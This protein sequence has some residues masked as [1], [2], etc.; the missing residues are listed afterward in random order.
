MM[1]LP[2]ARTTRTL[3]EI[4]MSDSDAS[5]K[6]SHWFLTLLI[7]F[8]LGIGASML[9]P[10]YAGPYLDGFVSEPTALEG[11]VMDKVVETDRLVLKVSTAEGVLLASFTDERDDVALLVQTGDTVSLAAAGYRPFLEDPAV[12]AVHESPRETT[13]DEGDESS[14]RRT[15]QREM[16]SRLESLEQ[17]LA[18]LEARAS[19]LGDDVREE[20]GEQLIDLRAKRDM[21]RQ[22]LEEMN[23]ASGA[24]WEDV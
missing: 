4:L 6:K 5:K 10:R 17:Q 20:Y 18:K 21:A 22:K 9:F 12:L 8:L 19:E 3:A 23:R 14:P 24:A 11:K 2:V 16:K 1:E 13:R 7:G 15:Y